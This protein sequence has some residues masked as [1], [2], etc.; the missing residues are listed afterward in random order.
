MKV[1]VVTVCFNEI[2]TIRRTVDS[3]LEQT[4]QD[5]QYIVIDGN[6]TDGTS[7][8][9]REYEE[10]LDPLVVE[11]DAGLYHAMNKSISYLTGDL[12]YFLNADDYFYDP[13]VVEMAARH[14]ESDPTLDILSG[15]VNFFN[16]PVVR[17]K[18]YKRTEFRF[19]NKLQLYKR[20]NGQQCIFSKVRL[21]DSVGYFDTRF[22]ICADYDWLL[23]AINQRRRIKFVD[24][25]FACVDYTGISYTHN[26]LRKREKRRIVFEN[27]TFPELVLFTAARLRQIV[28]KAFHA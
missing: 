19:D 12:V 13:R 5:I 2:A 4:H 18:P 6:S 3:V 7:A 16:V 28:E 24:D 8:V 20:P 9:L 25:Y 17:G 27:S 11:S 10:N 22:R 1:S 26:A 23:R 15:R 14:F 21:F